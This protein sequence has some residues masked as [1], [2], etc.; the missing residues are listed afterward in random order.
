MK[1]ILLFLSAIVMCCINAMAT[2]TETFKTGIGF[3]EG[4]QAAV[5]TTPTDYTSSETGIQ[6]TVCG[7]NVNTGNYL[8]VA[9]KVVPNAYISWSLDFDC[10]KIALATTAG[11]SANTG[12]TINIYADNVIIESN[13]KVNVQNHI[14][15]I[16]IPEEYRKAGTVYK[17]ESNTTSYNSQFTSFTYYTIGDEVEE[18]VVPEIPDAPEGTINVATA[19][20]LISKGYEGE[21]TV[22]GYI[23]SITE[24]STQFGNATYDISDDTEGTN[25]LGVYRGYWKNNE[26][27]VTGN[28]IEV[29]GKITVTGNLTN[30]KGNTPQFAQEKSYVLVYTAPENGEID[31]PVIPEPETSATVTQNWTKGLGLPEGSDKVVKEPATYTAADTGIEYTLYGVYLNTGYIMFNSKT[32]KECYVEWALD[33]TM[34]KLV[35]KTTSG[36]STNENNYANI[37]ANNNLIETVFVGVQNAEIDVNIPTEYQAAGTVYKVASDINVTANEQFASFTYH[38]VLGTSNVNDELITDN[39][40][41]EYYNLQGVKVNYPISGQLYIV[42]QGT[43][44]TKQIMR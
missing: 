19:L 28:E 21:A 39:T 14:Y 11:G 16:E 29:G 43:K 33:F 20:D 17:I 35:L 32:Y 34:D 2:T 44:V 4:A 10:E 1:K 13:Y 36:C 38:K 30:Y 7:V 18:P 37:Y 3:P 8:M 31:E 12:N 5:P 27:F 22:E 23:T 25:K 41:V 6:Y 42:R 15:I 24:I 26:K 9:G 40:P